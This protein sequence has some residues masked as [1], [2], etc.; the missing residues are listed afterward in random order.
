MRLCGVLNRTRRS[1]T[2]LKSNFTTL[3]RSC[4]AGRAM[5]KLK[6]VL[7]WGLLALLLISCATSLITNLT[8]STLPRN[9]SGQYLVE[10]KLDTTQQTLRPDSVTPHVHVGFDAYPMRP[11]LKMTNRWEALVPVAADKD[12]II[13]HFKVDY[14]YNRFGQPGKG[15]RLSPEYKLTIK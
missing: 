15:S 12:S 9:P 1:G 6:A 10:M 7:P 14:E 13:Y 4:N 2:S 11:T 8:P 3:G 5:R